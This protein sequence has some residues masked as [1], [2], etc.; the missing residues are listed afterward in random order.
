[1][2]RP[3]PTS[4]L[5]PYTTLFRSRH[6]LLVTGLESHGRPGGNVEPHAERLGT[7]EAQRAVGLE[8]VEVGTDL[9]RAVPSVGDGQLDRPPP[10]VCD[11]V[12]LSEQVLPRN[13]ARV[14]P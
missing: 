10:L 6:P 8:E 1:M 12:T 4:T 14:L 3:P 13:H 2:L 5:F 11:D 7:V 9:D